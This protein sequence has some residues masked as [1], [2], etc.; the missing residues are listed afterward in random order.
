MITLPASFPK[1]V[2]KGNAANELKGPVRGGVRPLNA[3]LLMSLAGVVGG[4][5][6]KPSPNGV[7]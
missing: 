7:F 2:S 4:G 1:V 5:K 6:G 3:S